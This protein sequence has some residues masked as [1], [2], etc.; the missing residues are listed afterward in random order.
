[1]NLSW[2]FDKYSKDL[3]DAIA[4][5]TNSSNRDCALILCA[6]SDEPHNAGSVYPADFDS[7]ISVCAANSRGRRLA[8]SRKTGDLMILGECID[9]DSPSYF[10]QPQNSLSGSSVATALATGIASVLLVYAMCAA[11]EMDEWKK[12][13]QRK[14]MFNMLKGNMTSSKHKDDNYVDPYMLFG[15]KLQPGLEGKWRDIFDYRNYMTY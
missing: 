2:T 10:K 6:T 15:K 12:F 9:A 5:A 4:D 13:K 7:T 8:E 3:D 11:P 1:M 14:I